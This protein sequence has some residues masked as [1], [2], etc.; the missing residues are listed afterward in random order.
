VFGA[1]NAVSLITVVKTT[2][3]GSPAIGTN[4]L[5]AVNDYILWYARDIRQ[6]K[7]RQLYEERVFGGEGATQYNS[8][9]S[10]DGL[11]VRGMTL[12]RRPRRTQ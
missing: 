9:E 11:V 1:D 6:I 7:Y 8:I 4:V 10:P 3:A 2:G 5:A 12:R